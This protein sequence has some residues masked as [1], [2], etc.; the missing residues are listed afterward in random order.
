MGDVLVG[1]L[2]FPEAPRWRDGKLWFS[3]F[4]SHRVLTVDLSG[5]LET[6][7]EVPQRP[8]GL[9]WSSGPVMAEKTDGRIE[10]YR[11]DVPGTGLP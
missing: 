6:I 7:V 2:T 4:Y 8:S 5:R 11:V 3:D 9:G 10:T 1:G